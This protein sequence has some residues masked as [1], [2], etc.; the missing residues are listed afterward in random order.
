MNKFFFK[1]PRA[2]RE[3]GH[4]PCPDPFLDRNRSVVDCD[5]W[6]GEL[7]RVDWRTGAHSHTRPHSVNRPWFFH[8]R[9]RSQSITCLQLEYERYDGKNFSCRLPKGTS[10]PFPLPSS[11]L[12]WLLLP[13]SSI[14]FFISP[15]P[16]QRPPIGLV[17]YPQATPGQVKNSS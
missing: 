9:E 3:F 13:L 8:L 15:T 2:P 6:A 4:Q 16:T 11:L 7:A 17:K 1:G 10:V 12:L 5:R 14:S